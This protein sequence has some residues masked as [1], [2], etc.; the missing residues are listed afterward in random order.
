MNLE[1]A[2]L[3]FPLARICSLNVLMSKPEKYESWRSA[4]DPWL[5]IVC[6]DETFD[7]AV[8]Q[9]LRRRGPW[10]GSKRG[11]VSRLKSWNRSKLELEGYF[12]LYC[13]QADFKPEAPQDE[14]PNPPVP[15]AD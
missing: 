10:M 4:A 14:N 15:P 9:K 2:I 1:S 3:R 12:V 8:P 5:N 13:H 6:Y 11:P 7:H